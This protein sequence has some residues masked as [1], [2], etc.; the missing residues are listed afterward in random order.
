MCI[1]IDYD[2]QIHLQLGTRS[3]FTNDFNAALLKSWLLNADF[4]PVTNYY[5][6]VRTWLSI[7]SSLNQKYQ[8]LYAKQKEKSKLKKLD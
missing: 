7:F 8:M 4:Q 3:C 1:Y 5:K 6:A 2:Y